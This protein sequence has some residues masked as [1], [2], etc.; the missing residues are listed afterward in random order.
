MI[1][2]FILLLSLFDSDCF[3][4]ET[5]ENYVLEFNVDSV[6]RKVNMDCLGSGYQYGIN[7][8]N[9]LFISDTSIFNN[10]TL[11]DIEIVSCKKLKKGKNY[12]A[13]FSNSTSANFI[14]LNRVLKENHKC[15]KHTKAGHSIGLIR[16]K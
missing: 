14:I 2:Y 1:K 3:I 5:S 12:Y 11:S 16:C 6:G 4:L 13:A 9:L 10:L 15:F 7:V 8:K